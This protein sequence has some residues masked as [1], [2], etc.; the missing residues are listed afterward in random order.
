MQSDRPGGDEPE[1][2]GRDLH[3]AAVVLALEDP[4]HSDHGNFPVRTIV[5]A[6]DQLG[7]LS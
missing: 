5:M 6:A 7:T 3:E 4:D 2:S 1:A